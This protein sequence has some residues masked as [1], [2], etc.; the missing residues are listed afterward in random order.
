[1][2]NRRTLLAAAAT[3]TSSVASAVG[4]RTG[5]S[6]TASFDIEKRGTT[7]RLER[8]PSLDAE[9][10]DDF[11]NGIRA[12]RSKTLVPAARDRFNE[13]LETNGHDPK[14]DLPLARILELVQ[15]ANLHTQNPLSDDELIFI[16]ENPQIVSKILTVA[17]IL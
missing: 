12:W 7:G 17:P 11:F 10:R 16:A 1:M 8:L 13:I 9:L 15:Y 14:K 5:G 3:A 4:A 6:K 2:I